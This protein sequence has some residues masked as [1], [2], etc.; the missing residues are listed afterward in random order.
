MG[1]YGGLGSR[2]NTFADELVLAFMTGGSFSLCAGQDKFSRYIWAPYFENVANFAFCDLPKLHACGYTEYESLTVGASVSE[3]LLKIDREYIDDLKHFLF[4]YIWTYNSKTQARVDETLRSAGLTGEPYVGVHVR[5]GDKLIKEA[6]YIPAGQYANAVSNLSSSVR[7]SA[8]ASSFVQTVK[9][10]LGS[11]SQVYLSSDDSTVAQELQIA[12][13]PA[14]KV[15]TPPR[16]SGDHLLEGRGYGS[17]E[18]MMSVLV[19]VEALRKAHAFVGTASS[20][21]GRLA[22][23]LR[24]KA[25]RSVSLDIDGDW[26]KRRSDF[27]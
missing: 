23:F 5:R 16:P 22:Y 20:N 6:K 15:L 26:L 3:S 27:R 11:I 14:V 17:D 18:E 9:R 25:S 13:G 1:H 7:R 24:P 21:M 4:P 19:D 12:L 8:L 10:E 2:V